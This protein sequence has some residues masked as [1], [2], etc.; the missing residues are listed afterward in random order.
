ML[1]V[2]KGSSKTLQK[3][4][5]CFCLKLLV[6]FFIPLDVDFINENACVANLVPIPRI[7]LFTNLD[8]PWLFLWNV[9]GGCL[10]LHQR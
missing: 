5:L 10:L 1:E 3:G 6:Q 8:L 2:S 4:S 9:D 7:A